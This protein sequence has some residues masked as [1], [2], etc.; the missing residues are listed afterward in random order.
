MGVVSGLAFVAGVALSPTHI[1]PTLAL[2]AISSLLSIPVWS[3]WAQTRRQ[4]KLLTHGVR[5]RA[6]MQRIEV[7]RHSGAT[8]LVTFVYNDVNGRRRTH[9]ERLARHEIGGELAHRARFDVLIHEESP[10]VVAPYLHGVTFA[11][12]PPEMLEPLLSAQRE[13]QAEDEPA[14][15]PVLSLSP[16]QDFGEELRVA[17]SAPKGSP[18]SAPQWPPAARSAPLRDRAHDGT[19]RSWFTRLRGRDR[20]GELSVDEAGLQWRLEDRQVCLLWEE[21][22]IVHPS[23]RLRPQGRAELNLT[24]RAASAHPSEASAAGSVVR[25]KAVVS[26]QQVSLTVP[27]K[28]EACPHLDTDDFVWLWPLLRHHAALQGR[29]A[30]PIDLARVSSSA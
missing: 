5:R 26:Q 30:P 18:S 14:D 11:E 15:E 1:W 2:M 19:L 27:V 13:L 24:L 3:A 22:W 6:W 7:P 9:T 28:W 10:G 12:P 4:W 23:V 20:I 8:A 16:T 21:P 29:P 17:F 25:F